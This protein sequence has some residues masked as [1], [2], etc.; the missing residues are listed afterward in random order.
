M[1]DGGVSFKHY[2]KLFTV[3]THREPLFNSILLGVLTV[4]V[5]GSIGVFPRLSPALF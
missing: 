1:V 2:V 3:S 4:V 5:C